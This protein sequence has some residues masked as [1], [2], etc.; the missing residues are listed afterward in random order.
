MKTMTIH[1]HLNR[2]TQQTIYICFFNERGISN[3]FDLK[4]VSRKII[5]LD[6]I[7]VRKNSDEKCKRNSV[8][9]STYRYKKGGK[10]LRGSLLWSSWK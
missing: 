5:N 3:K 7:W 9:N 6:E 1:I 4:L 10:D 2:F 8:T